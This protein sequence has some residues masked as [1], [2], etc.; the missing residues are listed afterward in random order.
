MSKPP[1]MVALFIGATNGIGQST[2]KHFVKYAK[3]PKV[4][5]AG[6]SKTSA[7]SLLDELK[8]LNPQATLIF[9]ES[10]ISLMRNI[11]KICAD[12]KSNE[13]RMDLIFLSAGGLSLAGRQGT[14]IRCSLPGSLTNNDF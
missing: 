12:I 13:D 8:I 10:Q 11:D 4:Y 7:A 2:L 1:G 6:R 5:I 14:L 9:L 3:A